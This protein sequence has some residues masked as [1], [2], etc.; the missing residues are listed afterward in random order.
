MNFSARLKI[1]VSSH[2]SKIFFNRLL[3]LVSSPDLSE[4]AP[5][6]TGRLSLSHRMSPTPGKRAARSFRAPYRPVR[7]P[8]VHKI[9]VKHLK[10]GAA[11]PFTSLV[12][13]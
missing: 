12:T 13:N 9:G 11:H 6:K 4:Q 3:G 10:F 1:R 7:R 2:I 5:K 8:L